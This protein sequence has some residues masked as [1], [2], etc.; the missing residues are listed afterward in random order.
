VLAPGFRDV[1]SGAPKAR[2]GRCESA[3]VFLP[4]Q[5]FLSG[6]TVG[7]MN[8]GVVLICS[9]P[10]DDVVDTVDSVQAF[11]PDWRVVVID[12]G[13]PDLRGDGLPDAVTVLPP[14][15]Y[16][17]N[18][19]GGLWM[20]YCYGLNFILVNDPPLFILQ[21]DAD[22]LVVSSGLGTE[23]ERVFADPQVGL[24]GV[25]RIDP[26]GGRRDFSPI[27]RAIAAETEGLRSW[28]RPLARGPLR[29]LLVDARRHG[30]E[31]GEHAL[32]G[33]TVIRTKMLEDWARRGWLELKG[34]QTSH[35]PD[36]AILSLATRASGYTIAELGGRD[37]P[38]AVT[39][40]G[41]PASPPELTAS[42]AL[43][44][45]SVRSWKDWTETEIRSFFR[46]RR[47]NVSA[48]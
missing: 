31:T 27:A 9:A 20:K 11:L 7:R 45:H 47:R 10:R 22:A 38:F 12:D 37:G 14:L 26:S 2:Q 21:L 3:G 39:W 8:S 36:D 35:V 33:A 28:I 43:V 40:K 17:R 15:N 41:L 13:I 42:G 48:D 29:R 4:R 30:Y 25:H 34:L 46:D 5:A 44:V 19:F 16:P 18:K 6:A 1:G 32:G 24:A 23:I